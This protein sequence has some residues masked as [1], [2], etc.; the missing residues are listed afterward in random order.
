MK[1]KMN[2][3]E[4]LH[5]KTV[6]DIVNEKCS[7]AFDIIRNDAASSSVKRTFRIKRRT[8]I[9]SIAAAAGILASLPAAAYFARSGFNYI[10]SGI[11]TKDPL[12]KNDLTPYAKDLYDVNLQ[13]HA[14]ITMQS[15]YCD[16]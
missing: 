7:E 9:I 16:G 15:I 5:G 8:M 6:P 2:S 4:L 10:S 14:D 12:E 13:T 11:Y 1:E 3:S